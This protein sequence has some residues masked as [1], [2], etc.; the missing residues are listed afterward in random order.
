[1][2]DIKNLT[3]I[4]PLLFILSATILTNFIGDT[5]GCKMQKIFSYNSY[6]KYF[7]ILFVIYTSITIIDKKTSPYDHF[8]KSLYIL[9]LFILFTKNTLRMTIIIGIL[10]ILLFIIDDYI[11]YYKNINNKSIYKNKIKQLENISKYLKYL[12]LLL[13]IIG[14]FIYILKQQKQFND[15][16]DIFKLYKGSKCIIV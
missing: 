2:F 11:N 12:I 8:M 1:M 15:D 6:L 7:V 16:F 4:I 10:M 14:H 5:I 13:I 3:G 9:I